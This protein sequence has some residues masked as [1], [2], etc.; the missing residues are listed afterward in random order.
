MQLWHAGIVVTH[1]SNMDNQEAHGTETCRFAYSDQGAIEHSS[2]KNLATITQK[3]AMVSYPVPNLSK[4]PSFCCA[5]LDRPFFHFPHYAILDALPRLVEETNNL[6]SDVLAA[7]LLV[8]HDAGRGGQDDIAELTGGQQLD[9]PVLEVG[10]ADVVAG[11]DD[12]GLVEAA[13]QLDDDLAGAVVIDLLELANVAWRRAM[14]AR[15][16][17]QD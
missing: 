9:D 8:V 5:P 13:V 3:P 2:S 4:R 6:S 14:S 1:D 17:A 10:Q 11:G 7:G 15:I 16:V 12:T